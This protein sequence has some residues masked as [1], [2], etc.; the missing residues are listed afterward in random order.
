MVVLVQIYTG[1]VYRGPWLLTVCVEEL[2]RR[3][4]SEPG[5]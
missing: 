3:N 4:E 1:M 2:R 5:D